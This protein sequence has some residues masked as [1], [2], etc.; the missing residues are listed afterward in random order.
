M[1]R[2]NVSHGESSSG[3]RT[4]V[5]WERPGP[6]G[7]SQLAEID[8]CSRGRGVNVHLMGA[9]LGSHPGWRYKSSL[10]DGVAF[11]IR[12]HQKHGDLPV[13]EEVVWS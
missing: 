12:M 5:V 1:S 7:W 11:T 4:I 10:E 3:G 8:E 9:L 13:D 6:L 2:V